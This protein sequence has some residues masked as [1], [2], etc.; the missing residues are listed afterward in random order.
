MLPG[1]YPRDFRRSTSWTEIGILL[2]ALVLMML[3][4]HWVHL[5]QMAH[6]RPPPRWVIVIPPLALSA[7]LP[8]PDTKAAPSQWRVLPT[9]FG[10]LEACQMVLFSMEH[11]AEGMLAF[12]F[13]KSQCVSE[14]DPHFKIPTVSP[15]WSK[16]KI[17]GA[18]PKVPANDFLSSAT[19]V[20]GPTKASPTAGSR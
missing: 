15:D 18:P 8:L 20:G 6:H 11:R 2:I 7:G 13:H 10:S 12:R 3:V 19:R 14:D 4:P 1:L 9:R 5:Y 16:A 17:V